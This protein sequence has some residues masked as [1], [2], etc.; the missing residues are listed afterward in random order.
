M[1]ISYGEN[2][3]DTNKKLLELIN[4]FS[5]VRGKKLIYRTLLHFYTLII[6]YQKEK[7][8]KQSHLKLPQKE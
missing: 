6:N 5:E 7:L 3:E 8:R 2:I 4:D 1:T